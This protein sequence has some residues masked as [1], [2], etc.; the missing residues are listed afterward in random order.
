MDSFIYFRN[1]RFAQIIKY[2][3]L[4]E[5]QEVTRVTPFV[6]ALFLRPAFFNPSIMLVHYIILLKPTKS[7]TKPIGPTKKQNLLVQYNVL[8]KIKHD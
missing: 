4:F 8:A 5:E 3:L 7:E 2:K 1:Y 6:Y